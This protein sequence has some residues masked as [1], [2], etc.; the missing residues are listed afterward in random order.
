MKIDLT[1]KE[2][3][4]LNAILWELA[5]ERG[6]VFSSDIWRLTDHGRDLCRGIADGLEEANEKVNRKTGK[7]RDLSGAPKGSIVDA[8]W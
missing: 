6:T 3:N 4:I 8:T 5:E 1:Y 7:D 2:A